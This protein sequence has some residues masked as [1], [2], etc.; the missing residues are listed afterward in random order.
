[1]NI[2][3]HQKMKRKLLWVSRALLISSLGSVLVGCNIFSKVDPK[4]DGAPVA[5]RA[6][7]MTPSSKTP[8]SDEML[9]EPILASQWQQCGANAQN[10]SGP[11]NLSSSLLD[12]AFTLDVS[13]H[14]Q[15]PI[16]PI[17]F[18]QNIAVLTYG[19]M[20]KMLDQKGRCVWERSVSSTPVRWGG[21]LASDD[22]MIYVMAGETLAA[23]DGASGRQIWSQTLTVPVR[24]ALTLSGRYLALLTLNNTLSV[25]DKTNGQMLWENPGIAE[26]TGFLGGASPAIS[27]Q[28][29]VSAFSSGNIGIFTLTDGQE[30]AHYQ[31]QHRLSSATSVSVAQI[32]ASP[33]IHKEKIYVLFYENQLICLD[34]QTGQLLWSQSE[35]GTQ[36][37]LLVGQA[38]F[39][40]TAQNQIKALNR[41]TGECFWKLDLPE[42]QKWFGPAMAGGLLYILSEQGALW[43]LNPINH[44]V[45]QRYQLPGRYGCG[46]IVA[47]EGMWAL[48]SEGKLTYLRAA[49]KSSESSSSKK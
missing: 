44:Q 7:A 49:T 18:A 43:A 47:H 3:S 33:V 1:M 13:E 25:Y 37:P 42:G 48:S 32:I 29:I 20:V 27:G 30:Q 36:N 21:S 35:S 12:I 16:S 28:T 23:L 41:E 15:T 17:A 2:E 11:F 19:G 22:K 39:L 31:K 5:L 45:R 4:L 24:A 46:F 14:Y 10:C 9:A 8:L 26:D 38:L 40:V 34:M 6:E